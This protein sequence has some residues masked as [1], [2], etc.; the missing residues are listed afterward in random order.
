MN[1]DKAEVDGGV[2]VGHGLLIPTSLLL[3]KKI[4]IDEGRLL[5]FGALMNSLVLHDKLVTLPA[6]IPDHIL[7]SGLYRYLRERGLLTELKI[8]YDEFEV[9]QKA[10]MMDLFRETSIPKKGG[11]ND[12]ENFLED[13]NYDDSFKEEANI[14]LGDLRYAYKYIEKWD[15]EKKYKKN[16]VKILQERS[17]LVKAI[18]TSKHDDWITTGQSNLLLGSTEEG[19]RLHSLRTAAYWEI[20]G[21]RRIPFMPDF[22]RIPIIAGYNQRLSQSI[23]IFL[24]NR[25]DSINRKEKEDTPQFIETMTIPLPAIT[26]KFLSIYNEKRQE[27]PET[28]D[29][30]R[31]EFGEHR[32]V[33]VDWEERLRKAS[34]E[35]KQK[36]WKEISSSIESLK[37]GNEGEIIVNAALGVVE[38]LNNLLLSKSLKL[39]NAAMLVRSVIKIFKR[40][41]D[42]RNIN[43]YY[44][45][46]KEANKIMDQHDLL[47]E[48]FDSSLKT[49]TQRQR[50]VKLATCLNEL[51]TR[52]SV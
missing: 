25:I 4:T 11:A 6:T 7:Q 2:L 34:P 22:L 41:F 35:E 19:I 50:F 23:R 5:D 43:Y 3:E 49:E 9:N 13:G 42:R 20:S 51:T 15:D 37:S 52:P 45:G 44:T 8:S 18:I 40:F 30:L 36:V 33:I 29:A 38:D 28:L 27:L 46:M 48:T 26:S 31:E 14:V 47:E 1:V 32:K 39:D 10:E 24:Q 21:M 12:Q 17:R 16:E